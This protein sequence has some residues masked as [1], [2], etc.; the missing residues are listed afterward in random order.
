MPIR[1]AGTSV[2]VCQYL[3][4]IADEFS[5]KSLCLFSI[6]NRYIDKY[7]NK[8]HPSVIFFI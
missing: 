5:Q 1:T 8:G 6:K 4:K 3:G 2:S 7:H